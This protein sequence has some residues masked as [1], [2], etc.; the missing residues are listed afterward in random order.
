MTP[1]RLFTS[2]M[3]LTMVGILQLPGVFAQDSAL[4]IRDITLVNPGEKPAGNQTIVIQGDKIRDVGLSGEIAIPDAAHIIE[5]KGKYAIPGLIDTHVH[6]FQSGGLYTRPDIIDLR[7]RVPY[8]QELQRIRNELPETFRRYLRSGVTAVADVG[9][10]MWNFEVRRRARQSSRAPLVTVAGPLISTYQPQALTTGDPPIIKPP[11]IDSARSLVRAQ[12]QQGA[13]YIKIWYIVRSGDPSKHLELV[14]A[15]ID[16]A[17]RHNKPV[18]VHATEL[19]TARAAVEAGADA[20]VHSVTDTVVTD[21][22]AQLLKKNDVIYTPTLTVFESYPEVFSQQIDLTLEEHRWSDPEVISSLFDLSKMPA[23]SLPRFIQNAMKQKDK[24]TTDQEALKNLKLLYNAGVTIAAGTDAGNIGTPHGPAIYREFEL[25][26]QAGLSPSE[27]LE[28]A[29]INGARFMGKEKDLGSI[30]EGKLADLLVL[31][32]NP[33]EDIK[34]TGSIYRVIKNGE[35]H[36]PEQLLE[37]SPAKVVQRQVN[38]YNARDIEGFASF[39][40]EDIRIYAHPKQ[41]RFSGRDTLYAR[42]KTQFESNPKQHA[43]IQKRI[44]LGNHVFDRERVTGL[45]RN[46]PIQAVAHYVIENGKIQEVY[47]TH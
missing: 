28:T 42:Y 7:S 4:V 29:T 23:D 12:V 44:V 11:S 9:G 6:F 22:F 34:N 8:Q 2:V 19:T 31:E 25:M 14:S 10:P 45:S 46:G 38:A 24:V 26:R 5:G 43:A 41:L 1:S 21:S 18:L 39:Y 36:N 3:I 37:S 47:F 30:R 15:A 35:S 20:L 16:E 27:I 17:H 13:D 33:L 32:K 40:S